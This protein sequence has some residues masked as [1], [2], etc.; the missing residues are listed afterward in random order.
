[1]AANSST[2]AARSPQARWAIWSALFVFGLGVA[3]A[4]YAFAQ[5]SSTPRATDTLAASSAPSAVWAAGTQRA[6]AFRLSD[7]NGKSFSLASLRGRNVVVTFIDPLCRDFCPIEAQRLSDA[8][9]TLPAGSRP[10]VVAVSVNA[11]GNTRANL[12]L[13]KRKWNVVPQWRWGI[14]SDATLSSVWQR[15]HIAV[16]VTTKKVA[17][18]AVRNVAHTEA[19]YVI[20][21][22]GYERALFLWPYR[23]DGVAS[24]LRSLG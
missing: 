21:A 2:S 24:V 5:R 13:D 6:P 16:L 18:I 3:G 23:A 9:R 10:A 4:L 22:A 15:F 20:D 7:E 17:G 8:V 19:S 14:G 11:F 1:V 12:L